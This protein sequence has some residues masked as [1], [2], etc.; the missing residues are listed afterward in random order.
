MTTFTFINEEYN[1]TN[2]TDSYITPK[3]IY[4]VPSNKIARI[5]FDGM[6][7]THDTT[8][9]F[10][11]ASFILFSDGTNVHR[12]HMYGMG[13]NNDSAMKMISFYNPV[14]YPRHSSNNGSQG[15]EYE[16]SMYAQPQS[17]ISSGTVETNMNENSTGYYNFTA[18]S[19][20]GGRVFGPE[21][22]FMKENE[23]LKFSA[24]V[25]TNAN[26]TKYVN[27]RCAVFLED[28]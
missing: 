16:Y 14:L 21:Y 4:T 27:I 24:A 3:S 8:T 5:R 17:F 11:H 23:V 22:F 20:Y 2:G 10:N 15:K 25:G 12:K 7:A 19:G 6:F 18:T 9:F 1:T 26:A 28:E 13:E